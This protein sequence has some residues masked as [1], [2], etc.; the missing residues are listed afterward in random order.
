MKSASEITPTS[1]FHPRIVLEE[2][3]E[4]PNLTKKAVAEKMGIAPTVLSEIISGKRKI[5]TLAAIKLEQ[6]L[7]I[8]ALYISEYAIAIGLLYFKKRFI[9][10]KNTKSSLILYQ[11]FT[12]CP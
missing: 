8:N 7:E 1:F 2:E 12:Y 11:F 4:Y 9:E 3:I 5:T 10:K 6:A